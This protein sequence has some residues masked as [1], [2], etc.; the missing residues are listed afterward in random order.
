MFD[1]EDAKDVT[2]LSFYS[3]TRSRVFYLCLLWLQW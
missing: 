1:D 2:W 3:W